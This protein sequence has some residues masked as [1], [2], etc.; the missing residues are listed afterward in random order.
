MPWWLCT[1]CSAGGSI[2]MKGAGG[3]RQVQV[4]LVF[5]GRKLDLQPPVMLWDSDLSHGTEAVMGK[6]PQQACLELDYVVWMIVY[7]AF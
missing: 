1:R 3:L 2:L 7:L 5:G 4:R 6:Y